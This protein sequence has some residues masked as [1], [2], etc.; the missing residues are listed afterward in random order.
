MCPSLLD[1]AKYLTCVLEIRSVISINVLI[2]FGSA[3]VRNLNIT[4]DKMTLTTNF[5][6][7]GV[8][9]IILSAANENISIIKQLNGS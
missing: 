6:Y 3:G 1:I 7:I 2:Y 5:S 8:E 4:N 9:S